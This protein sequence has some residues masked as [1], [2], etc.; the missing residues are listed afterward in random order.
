MK[1]VLSIFLV[2]TVLIS[3]IPTV[4][5]ADT[6]T[7]AGIK[8]VYD[9]HSDLIVDDFNLTDL[10]YTTTNGF[11][12]FEKSYSGRE[13]INTSSGTGFR[14]ENGYIKTIAQN[15][16]LYENNPTGKP[17]YWI[18]LKINV[19]KAGNYNLE[20]LANA[21]SSG[22]ATWIEAFVF[23]ADGVTNIE[24][25]LVSDNKLTRKTKFKADKVDETHLV[26]SKELDAGE[27][28]FVFQPA[29]N[30]T[31]SG[32][33]STG[34]YVFL[35][36]L[37]LTEGDG[38]LAVPVISSL[39]ANGN[40]VIATAAKM[41]DNTD[42]TDVTYSYAVADDD[43]ALAEVDANTGVVTGLADGNATIIA[44]ATKNGQSSSKSIEVHV[45]G[46][47]TEPDNTQKLTDAF[48]HESTTEN[49]V[50]V[51]SAGVTVNTYVYAV[52]GTKQNL[53]NSVKVAAG[54]ICEVDADKI[55]GMENYTFLYW[56]KGASMDK[57]QIVSGSSAYSFIPTVEATHLIA[58]FAPINATET[59]KAEFYNGNGQLLPD[60]TM[61]NDNTTIPALPSMAGYGDATHWELYGDNTKTQYKEGDRVPLSGNM[62]FVAQYKELEED[63]TINV[64]GGSCDADKYKYGDVVTCTPETENNFM[65][66]KK[67][68]VIVSTDTEYTFNAW[69]SCDIEAVYGEHM[70]T[71]KATKLLI[72]IFNDKLIMAEFIGLSNYGT[73]VEK[74]IMIGNKRFAMQKPF[75]TQFTLAADTASEAETAVAYAIFDDGTMITDK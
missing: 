38:S 7:T 44:T 49:A 37:T 8:V 5:A 14:A 48:A 54:T 73:V 11:W 72:D 70:F 45:L 67:D 62:I 3:L 17:Y 24:D 36:K 22:T 1:K 74:G 31:V 41:S 28:Y 10:T 20:I 50:E 66:W 68:G 12:Q 33:P 32:S 35:K 27:Y 18:G 46:P 47:V 43:T 30:R 13:V 59:A 39:T 23:K 19:P 40:Q 75:A 34:G 15:P 21:V 4:F 51:P 60:Y 64:I 57:K 16:T 58:V 52:D 71:G 42:A 63:I 65:C 6:E 69:E 29:T 25:G 26:G 55:E 53:D 9:F 61:E 2:L 56:A